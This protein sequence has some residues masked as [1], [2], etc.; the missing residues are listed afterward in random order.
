MPEPH[1]KPDEINV[2]TYCKEQINP[3]DLEAHAQECALI[4][5][6]HKK[7]LAS[8]HHNVYETLETDINK[9]DSSK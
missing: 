3:R 9:Q 7:S 8:K 4:P 5:E 6:D 2:C 1:Q